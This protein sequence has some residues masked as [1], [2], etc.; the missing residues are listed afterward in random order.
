LSYRLTRFIARNK[1]AVGATVVVFVTVL[2]AA[3]V[4]FS[5]A[6]E[7]TRQR[8]RA[9]SLAMRN[10]AV[11]DFVGS[12]LMEVA[13]AD[14]PIRAADLLERSQSMLMATNSNPEPQAAIL[15][16]LASFYLSTGKAAQGDAL[17]ARSLELTQNSSDQGLRAALLCTKAFAA[18]LLGQ[19]DWEK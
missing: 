14:Q 4:S 17:V 12:M 16:L 10:E 6:R 9:L 1:L 7:A 3:V 2:A 15:S 5:Q 13:P 11:V 19:P 18:T 8:D